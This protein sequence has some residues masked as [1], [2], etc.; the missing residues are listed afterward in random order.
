[1]EEEKKESEKIGEKEIEALSK[2]SEADKSKETR[3][4]KPEESKEKPGEEKAEKEKADGD[5][6]KIGEGEIEELRKSREEEDKK[7]GSES[8]S[9]KRVK[10]LFWGNKK[11][12]IV[13]VIVF[14]IFIMGFW[15]R[16]FPAR[17]NE[18]QALD[19]FLLYRMGQNMVDNNLQLTEL[20]IFRN[21]PFGSI[22]LKDEFS[23]PIY[24]PVILYT[25]FGMGMP[26]LQWAI[27]YPALMGALATIVMFFIGRELYDYRAGLFAAFF[28]AVIPAFITRTSAGFFDKEPTFG[29]FMLVTVY[30]FVASYKRDSWKLGI[31]AGVFLGVANISSGIGRYIYIFYFLFT[32]ILLLI[33]KHK[34]LLYSYGPTVIFAV[35]VQLL[36]PKGNLDSTFF[37]IFVGLFG[38]L[39]LRE[40]VGRF[41]LVKEHD[42]KY[43]V[44][45]LF[46]VIIVGLLIG[47]MFSDYLFQLSESLITVAF[48]LNPN[49]VGY[50]VAE[51]QPG[52]WNS[53]MGVSGLQFSGQA[54]PQLNSI[55]PY[56]TIYLFMFLGILVVLYRMIRRRDFALLLP[57]VWIIAGMWGVFL[58]IRLT[59]LFGPP[60]ALMAG[61]FFGWV[62]KKLLH[63]KKH[64]K[65][66][67]VARYMPFYLAIIIG[68]VV[69]VNVANAYVYS[70]G[71]GP[72][73]C[74]VNPQ[75]L[76][77][78]ERCLDINEDG[79]IT[80]AAG[81]P[82]Y[83]AMTF[84]RGVPMPK[85]IISW[86]DFGHWF[87]ARGETPS[88]SD[89]GKGP[90]FYIAEW[91]T[92]PVDQW[93]NFLPFVKEK[94][95]VSHIL[96]DY[97]L[98]GKYGAITA[99]ATGGEGAVG[100]LQLNQ[101]ETFQQ[102]N[103]TIQEFSA[104]NIAIWIPV[105]PDGNLADSPVFLV[106]QGGQYVQNGFVNDVCT[107][108]GML[109]VED[110]EPS[111]GGC[112]SISSLGVYYIPE[113]AKNT[114]FVSLQFMNGVGLPVEMVFDN[115]YINI[116]KVNY[117]QNQGNGE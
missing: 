89:G 78:G 66:E 111:V 38:V 9:L 83:E 25:I 57:L 41:K 75:I 72:S 56:L 20:D 88:V 102:G 63:L 1:V 80:Y 96:Q 76:I 54:L 10:S 114:I 24:F 51:Q 90:R 67:P 71:M 52:D 105:G 7:T 36:A 99:I 46:V 27:L 106:S 116:Y 79:S 108:Q 3:E 18:L 4:E 13:L 100:L 8:A 14:G 47:T 26:F 81:Q 35:V 55:A 37:Y 65:L 19:P 45:A 40:L 69:A 32:F 103:L 87:H 5:K 44:P 21:Y 15:L 34:K 11:T 113:S 33:N 62:I 6:G 17:F 82:W 58:F 73:I 110:K 22:P 68:L 64:G 43:F 107:E 104:G 86:W 2:G 48:V 109:H 94:Q 95:N 12:L 91:Y 74:I 16:S 117:D 84:L 61:L 101:G 92:A 39:I 115:N 85:N 31:L 112:V 59:F 98:P 42:L 93:D 29:F 50:T 77:D 30:F 60:A 23:V 49:P 97:T 53:M 28:L 70:N